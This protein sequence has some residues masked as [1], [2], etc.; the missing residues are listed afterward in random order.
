MSKKYNL[1]YRREKESILYITYFEEVDWKKFDTH[2]DE[3]Y[4]KFYVDFDKD[5]DDKLLVV[6]KNL[7]NK[8]KRNHKILWIQIDKFFLKVLLSFYYEIFILIL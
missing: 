5:S 6:I 1:D 8:N 3:I 2:S 7:Q 4:L